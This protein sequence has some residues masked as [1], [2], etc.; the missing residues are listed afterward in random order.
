ML[1]R[2]SGAAFLLALT[3]LHPPILRGQSPALTLGVGSAEEGWP[4]RVQVGALLDDAGLRGALD[5]ALPLRFHLRAELWRKGLLDRLVSAQEISVAILKDPLSEGYSVGNGATEH[6]VESLAEAQAHLATF[7][8]PNLRPRQNGRHYYIVTLE[9][10]TLSLSDLDELRR[11]L[12]GEVAPA[13]GG[14][15]SPVSAVG[16]GLRRLF[17]RVIG[18]PTRRFE[19]RTGTFIVAR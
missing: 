12:R 5:S 18:L 9:V 15:N 7:L 14:R 19:A 4:L 2:W 3:L 1:L 13:I 11:W 16:E 6:R 8:A 10:E 17:V